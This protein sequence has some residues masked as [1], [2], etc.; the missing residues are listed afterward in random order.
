[1][2]KTSRH[3]TLPISTSAFTFNKET[4]NFVSEASTVGCLVADVI[5]LQSLK[6][7]REVDFSFKGFSRDMEGEII[8]AVYLSAE[9]P[10]NAVV[11]YN[12]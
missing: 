12:D 4:G 8:S 1:M 3:S 11:I 9:L 10:C 5:R 7:G 6:T 2:Y